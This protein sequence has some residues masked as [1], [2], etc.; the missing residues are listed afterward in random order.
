[1]GWPLHTSVYQYQ[2]GSVKGGPRFDPLEGF[3]EHYTMSLPIAGIYLNPKFDH[4]L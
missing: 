1:M 3:G 4:V 2:A